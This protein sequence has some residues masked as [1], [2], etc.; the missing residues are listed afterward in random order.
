MGKKDKNTIFFF[1]YIWSDNRPYDQMLI[2]Q[3]ELDYL[4]ELRV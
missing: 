2:Q 1:G 3:P 4:A